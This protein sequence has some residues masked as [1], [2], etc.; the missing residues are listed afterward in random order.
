VLP[1]IEA[2]QAVAV[3]DGYTLDD[4]LS[5]QPAPGHTLA[6]V[7]IHLNSRGQRAIFSGDVMHVPL[8]I[9]Y[10]HWGTSLDDDPQLGV[11]SRLQLLED[12][13]ESRTLILPTHFVPDTGCFVTRTAGAFRRNGTRYRDGDRDQNPPSGGARLRSRG[14]D[15]AT[16]RF[17][18]PTITDVQSAADSSP[19]SGYPTR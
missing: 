12:C 3:D 10:P 18:G 13:A 1:V 15:N 14:L 6:H 5:V 4:A 11:R 8:Q 19:S 17:E 2:G 7:A 9:H 16:L